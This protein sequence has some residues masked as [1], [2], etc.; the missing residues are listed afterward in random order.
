M[1]RP[2]PGSL[3]SFPQAFSN[4]PCLGHSLLLSFPTFPETRSSRQLAH[5]L[6]RILSGHRR[7]WGAFCAPTA[8]VLIALRLVLALLRS[9]PS[10]RPQNRVPRPRGLVGGVGRWS[11]IRP[12]GPPALG[13]QRRRPEPSTA[14][15]AHG[16]NGDASGHVLGCL[17]VRAA[18]PRSFLRGLPQDSRVYFL[19]MLCAS[20][21]GGA[22][23]RL[24]SSL[25]VL[26]PPTR[27]G[28]LLWR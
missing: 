20:A 4:C 16:A 28:S 18:S 11:V 19:I 1:P 8:Q 9:T 17:D 12:Q 24:V 7:D 14:E 13:E 15:G 26:F 10:A 27:K 21:V 22:G 6:P 5:R 23:F 25:V 3:P 2:G